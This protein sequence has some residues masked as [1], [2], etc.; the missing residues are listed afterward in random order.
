[1]APPTSRQARS[2][3]TATGG[4]P[5]APATSTSPRDHSAHRGRRRTASAVPALEARHR[6]RTPDQRRRR[7]SV[8]YSPADG[9]ATTVQVKT[10]LAPDPPAVGRRLAVGWSFPHE[11]GAELLAVVLLSDDEV[12]LFTADE[13]RTIAQQHT[14]SGSRR[15]YWYT[16]VDM[17]QR[18]GIP[19]KQGDM[20]GSCSGDVRPTSSCGECSQLV[21]GATAVITERGSHD[22]ARGS[23]FLGA[24]PEMR[25]DRVGGGPCNVVAAGDGI[26]SGRGPGAAVRSFRRHQ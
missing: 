8:V 21:A 23:S 26:S 12:W 4:G 16:D 2:L 13:A 15:L 17:P 3:D 7:G 19:L 18:G 1:M 25:E 22:S 10:V 5:R 6:Q 11:L 24:L 20:T 14:T 9:R